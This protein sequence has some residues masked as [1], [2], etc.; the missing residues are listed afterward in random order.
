MKNYILGVCTTLVLVAVLTAGG[1]QAGLFGS[2]ATANWPTVES[3]FY[4]VEAYGFD[5][6]VYEWH[7]EINPEMTCITGFGEVGAIGLQCF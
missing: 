7:P 2:M 3:I 5:M 1:A 6:R 4:K